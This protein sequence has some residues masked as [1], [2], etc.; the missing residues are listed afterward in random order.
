MN[1]IAWTTGLAALA[2][3]AVTACQPGGVNGSALVPGA[4]TPATV[5]APASEVT[6]APEAPDP[7]SDLTISPVTGGH[8]TGSGPGTGGGNQDGTGNGDGSGDGT[9]D[10]SGNGDGSGSGSGD[11]EG[12]GDGS[13]SGAGSGSGDGSGS[14]S[15][16]GNGSGEGD[17]SGSGSGEWTGEPTIDYAEVTCESSG[18][19]Y[20]PVLRWKVSNASGLA[21]NLNSEGTADEGGYHNEETEYWETEG[22]AWM[23]YTGCYAEYGLHTYRLSTMGH[24]EQYDAAEKTIEMTGEHHWAA[25]TPKPRIDEYVLSCTETEGGEWDLTLYYSVAHATGMALSVDNP[26]IVGSFGT[27]GPSGTIDLPDNGCYASYGEQ[28]YDLY[29]VGGVEPQAVVNLTRTGEH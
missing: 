8:G 1:R 25:A 9:G 26:G 6:S 4:S 24:H 28:T 20:H 5:S 3:V 10:G 27:Y 29:T 15:G 21:V 19:E 18:D 7:S 12:E 11:G 13:G 2:C 16:D 23:P 22:E 17:G 14:G